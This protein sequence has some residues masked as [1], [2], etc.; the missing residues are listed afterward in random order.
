M[1]NLNGWMEEWM[2]EWTNGWAVLYAIE[3]YT[4]VMQ[5]MDRDK[6]QTDNITADGQKKTR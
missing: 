3:Q 2:D 6:K 5:Q 1:F 4:T